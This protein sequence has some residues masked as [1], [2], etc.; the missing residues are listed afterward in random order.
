MSKPLKYSAVLILV[1][2]SA[3]W[4]Y[5]LTNHRFL[6]NEF[7]LYVLIFSVPAGLMCF[8]LWVLLHHAIWRVVLGIVILIP[9]LGLWII[10]LLLVSIGFRIH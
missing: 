3:V 2:T 5:G 7:W 4:I 10:S 9:S 6:L 1:I 8:S